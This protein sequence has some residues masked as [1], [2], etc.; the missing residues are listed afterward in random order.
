MYEIS[1]ADVQ[2]IVV[3]ASAGLT[4]WPGSRIA[5]YEDGADYPS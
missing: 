5:M 2:H 1:N 4:V 3:S